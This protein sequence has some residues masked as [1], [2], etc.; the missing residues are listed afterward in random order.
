MVKIKSVEFSLNLLLSIILSLTLALTF[1]FVTYGSINR[2]LFDENRF[3]CV[4]IFSVINEAL[5]LRDFNGLE[6]ITIKFNFPYR[7]STSPYIIKFINV[8]GFGKIIVGEGDSAYSITLPCGVI[9]LESLL[10]FYGGLITI[11]VIFHELF[12]EIS[13]SSG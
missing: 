3:I 10:K 11:N 6:R 9:V 2:I 8:D 13:I 12:V 1:G 4:Y 5:S 7:L